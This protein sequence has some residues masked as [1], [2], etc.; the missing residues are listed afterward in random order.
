M[1]Q[2]NR[3]HFIRSS[4]LFSAPWIGWSSTAS[5][6]PPSGELRV[7]SFGAAGRAWKN[8]EG[9]TAI[10]NTTLVAVAEIDDRNLKQVL[11]RFPKTRTYRDWRELIEKE[12]GDL[13]AVV[14]G[15]PDHMHAPMAMSA[16][17]AGLHVYCEKP[18]TRTIHEARVLREFAEKKGL[19]TQMGNQR[20]QGE[21]NRSTVEALQE[22]IVGTVREIHCMQK[23]TWGSMSP[24]PA[25]SDPPPEVDW[26]L[27]LG[28]RPERTWVDGAFHPRNWRS[29]LG[30][31]CG[32]LGD[33]GCHIFHPWY[34]GLNP[35][36][37]VTVE[38]L[39]PAPADL[40]SW[41]TGV[42]VKWE[43]PGSTESGG[44]PFSVT[45]HDGGQ[46]APGHVAGA[47]GGKENVTHSGSVIIGSRGT[48]VSP[49]GSG[50]V[51]FFV[52][53]KELGDAV[54]PFTG[55]E[56]HHRNFVKA[57]RGENGGNPPLSHFGHAGPMTEAVLTGTYAVRVPG[58][59]LEW[60]SE[61]LK[62]TNSEAANRLV[63]E[64]G[65]KGWEVEKL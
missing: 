3:R 55:I 38:S 5:G 53:G 65:R 22:G 6:G 42:R 1:K 51:R 33:M 23:K 16:M 56:D 10:P 2:T 45:W 30:F 58:E 36:A 11:E 8:I 61:N 25:A 7:A 40:V 41:P 24:L 64:P 14:I 59:K 15:V 49:H 20:S 27:W 31:G 47:V 29:R 50:K 37:P 62:F 18:L 52:N 39:G 35:G 21:A 12:A 26:D 46:A 48:L 54:R 19:V 60:D 4:V 17:L 57:V 43:F 13:D 9:I 28:V 32:N 34:L 44:K 63:R